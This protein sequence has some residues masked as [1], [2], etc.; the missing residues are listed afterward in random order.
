MYA[1]WTTVLSQI[2]AKEPFLYTEKVLD[3]RSLNDVL[4]SRC[5]RGVMVYIL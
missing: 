3:V 5:V 2:L 1:G 4:K